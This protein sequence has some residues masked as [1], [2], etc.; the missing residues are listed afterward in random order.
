MQNDLDGP[1]YFVMYFLQERKEM[2]ALHTISFSIIYS[3]NLSSCHKY[4][5]QKLSNKIERL[6]T[7]HFCNFFP[8][9]Q[10]LRWHCVP[11]TCH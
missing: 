11:A 4:C 1:A 7:L 9:F 3:E 6:Q 8:N 5:C 10:G 2:L